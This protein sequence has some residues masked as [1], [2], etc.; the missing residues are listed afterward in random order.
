MHNF[1]LQTAEKKILASFCYFTLLQISTA[2]VTT[3]YGTKLGEYGKNL[4]SFFECAR[5]NEICEEP[6]LQSVY[7]PA[8]VIVQWVLN[9]CLPILLLVYVID[10]EKLKLH[11]RKKREGNLAM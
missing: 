1:K 2:L 10:F 5:Y 6:L 3:Y 4:Y 7:S 9:A 8:G 11:I